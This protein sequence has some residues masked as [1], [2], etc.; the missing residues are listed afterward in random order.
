MKPGDRSR[1]AQKI[2]KRQAIVQY[3]YKNTEVPGDGG[4]NMFDV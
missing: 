1:S 4:Q 3:Q 2:R